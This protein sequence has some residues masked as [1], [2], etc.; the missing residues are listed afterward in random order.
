MWFV[1]TFEGRMEVS[2]TVD[3]FLQPSKPHLNSPFV[4]PTSCHPTLLIFII[5]AKNVSLIK[6]AAK[7]LSQKCPSW[8]HLVI[9]A[10]GCGNVETILGVGSLPIIGVLP[11][12]P[13]TA[14]VHEALTPPQ[15]L[16]LPGEIVEAAEIIHETVDEMAADSIGGKTA[17]RNEFVMMLK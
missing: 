1:Q 6:I 13:E 16:G 5:A 17:V 12:I 3:G 9:L 4:P 8:S 10:I 15:C 11:L 14:S 7:N 2:A